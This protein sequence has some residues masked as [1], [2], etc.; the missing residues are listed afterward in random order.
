MENNTHFTLTEICKMLGKEKSTISEHITKLYKER[1][2]DRKNTMLRRRITKM[3]G[4]N[5][6]TRD[7][8]TYSIDVV[9]ALLFRV[10]SKQA[11]EFRIWATG[12]LRGY[13]LKALNGKEK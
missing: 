11:R 1:E 6:V 9:M 7:M 4:K 3:E 5:Y 2:L 10:K 13:Y 8:D 12:V